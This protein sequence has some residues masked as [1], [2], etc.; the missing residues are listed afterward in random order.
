LLKTNISSVQVSDYDAEEEERER[1][2][3]QF[4]KERE[5]SLA[6]ARAEKAEMEAAERARR[7]FTS[8]SPFSLVLL[9]LV[10][11]GWKIQKDKREKGKTE[12]DNKKRRKKELL[13]KKG[14]WKEKD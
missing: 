1:K 7:Y 11:L 6:R 13:K 8:S 12:L 5:E 3:E 4:R 14:N 9:C 10:F 2:A